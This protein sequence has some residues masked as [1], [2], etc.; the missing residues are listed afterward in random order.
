MGFVMDNA[1][2]NNTFVSA[3]GTRCEAE[4]IPF[5]SQQA[6]LCCLPHTVHLA[7]LKVSFM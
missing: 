4:D 3:I 5:D 2:N 6:R 7:A 1:S